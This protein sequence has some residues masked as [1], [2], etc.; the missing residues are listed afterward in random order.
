LEAA[1][2]MPAKW[3][4][5]GAVSPST[6]CYLLERR[7]ND[8]EVGEIL[9]M[10]PEMVRHDGKRARVLMIAHGAAERMTGG[11]IVSLSGAT[12]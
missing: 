11:K 1:L 12:A 4:G 9:G 7:L 8:S 10:S 3:W 6:A 2:A 5:R